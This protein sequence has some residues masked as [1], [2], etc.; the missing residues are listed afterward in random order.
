MA[1]SCVSRRESV[2]RRQGRRGVGLPLAEALKY[3]PEEPALIKRVEQIR[4]EKRAKVLAAQFARSER[5]VIARN[6]DKA[7]AALNEALEIAPGDESIQK[8]I[9]GGQRSQLMNA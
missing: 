2:D 9:R 1:S 8:K 3:T 5:E 7:I 6:W 4:T